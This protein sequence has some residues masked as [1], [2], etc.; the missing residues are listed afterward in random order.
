VC[1]SQSLNVAYGNT[2]IPDIKDTVFWNATPCVSC[3]NRFSEKR[4]AS[5]IRV[6]RTGELGTILAVTSD[7]SKMGRSAI[8]VTLMMEAILSSKTSVLTSATWCNIQD[9]GIL[10]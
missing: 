1:V 8:L 9:E 7:R 2:N 5:I 3:K 10:Q 6:E 4:I